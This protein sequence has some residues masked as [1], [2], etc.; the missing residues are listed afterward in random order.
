[1]VTNCAGCVS[2]VSPPPGPRVAAG[3]DGR[4]GSNVGVG[5]GAGVCSRGPRQG[6]WHP[7]G[8]SIML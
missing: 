1:M 8:N 3:D 6:R 7:V 2:W 5:M 4:G